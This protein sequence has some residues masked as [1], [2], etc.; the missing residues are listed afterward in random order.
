MSPDFNYSEVPAT[1]LHCLNKQC[2]H[3]AKE[4]CPYFMADKKKRFALGITHLLDNV[5]HKEALG[6]K[7]ELMAELNR[8]TYYRCYRKE[9]L[10]KPKEQEYIRQLFLKRGIKELLEISPMLSSLGRRY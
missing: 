4:S 10:L 8:T 5:P 7:R 1:F 2:K 6:I 3:S 9:R